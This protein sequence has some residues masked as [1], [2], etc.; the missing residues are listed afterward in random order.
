MKKS[1]MKLMHP[2]D[3]IAMIIK[4]I[5]QSK[6]TTTSGGNISIKDESG[7]VWITPA[8]IDKGTLKNTDIIHIK[9]D[10]KFEGKHKPSS[11]FPFHLAIYKCRPDIRQ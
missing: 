7:D 5:Y 4:K 10:G 1:D 2:R 8:S 9:S 11:E 6:L 3:Q